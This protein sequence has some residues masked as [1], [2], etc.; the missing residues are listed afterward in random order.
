MRLCPFASN[1]ITVTDGLVP[2]DITESVER[3]PLIIPEWNHIS[4]Q[5]FFLPLGCV[6][7][8][9]LPLASSCDTGL[10]AT[11]SR[12]LNLARRV[13]LWLHSQHCEV[14]T[15]LLLSPYQPYQLMPAILFFPANSLRSLAAPT[16][17]AHCSLT[18]LTC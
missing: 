15:L 2:R 18:L 10:L 9:S 16:S 13:R 4:C 5:S 11:C 3:N 14:F 8:G 1:F 12:P 7:T 17:P 6:A